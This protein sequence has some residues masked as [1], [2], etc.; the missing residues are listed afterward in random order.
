MADEELVEERK[1]TYDSFFKSSFISA[2]V[3]AVGLLVMALF[4]L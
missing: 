2:A 1:R 4:L 3:I